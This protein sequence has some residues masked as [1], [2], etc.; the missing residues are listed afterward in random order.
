MT[1]IMIYN[2]IKEAFESSSKIDN[3]FENAVRSIKWD[4]RFEADGEMYFTV[5][6]FVFTTVSLN[7]FEISFDRPS[8]IFSD[9]SYM[10]I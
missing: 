6:A 10:T 8:F 9:G 7:P 4:S 1:E 5:G 2:S 3:R